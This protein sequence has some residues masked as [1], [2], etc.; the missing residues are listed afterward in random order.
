MS[1]YYGVFFNVT[2]GTFI[3]LLSDYKACY[4]LDILCTSKRV[5][6]IGQSCGKATEVLDKGRAGSCNTCWLLLGAPAGQFTQLRRGSTHTPYPCRRAS[7][8]SLE[9]N[10]TDT[11][12]TSQHNKWAIVRRLED[13]T[14]LSMKSSVVCDVTPRTLLQVHRTFDGRISQ[15]SNSSLSICTAS[16]H[17]K[18][19]QS[20]QQ[21][22]KN[23]LEESI[24]LWFEKDSTENFGHTDSKVM[25]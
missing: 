2:V 20:F 24:A 23:F 14:A 1:Q 18:H 9:H 10:V 5:L 7:R 6:D 17:R 12:S 19:C 21:F 8:W 11:F 3:K 13:H 15:V 22:N 16:H 4:V 25:S